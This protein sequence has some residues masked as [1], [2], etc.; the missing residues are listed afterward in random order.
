MN[1]FIDVI[2]FIVG[3]IFSVPVVFIIL[4]SA[5]YNLV[6]SA[7]CHQQFKDYNPKFGIISGCMI[8]YKG[9]RIPS[10]NFRIVKMGND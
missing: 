8:T 2:A 3:F 4:V 6:G 1:K 9:N 10:D 5:S 7:Q